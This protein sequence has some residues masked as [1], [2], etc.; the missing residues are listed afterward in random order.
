MAVSYVLDD[1]FAGNGALGLIVLKT[2]ETMEVELR[3]LFEAATLACY[4]SRIPM[5][6]TITPETLAD[7]ARDLPEAAA[8]LPEGTPIAAIGYGC[9]SGSTVIGPDRVAELV[10]RAQPAARVTNPISAVMAALTALGTRRIGLLTP[11]LPEVTEGMRA[12]LAANGFDVARVASFEQGEDR[13]V[14]RI[15]EA[16]TLAAI[17]DLA[18]DPSVEAVFASCTNLRTF[19]IIAAAEAATGKPVVSSNQA[20]GWHMLRLAGVRADGPGRLFGV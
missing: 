14:A 20:L 10:R 9:T 15:S 6:P 18:A 4:H 17:R 8:L 7:M 2:D 3:G 5:R 16:S 1:G 11:Y 13:L 19:G 12:L